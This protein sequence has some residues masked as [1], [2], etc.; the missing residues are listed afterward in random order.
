GRWQ[1]LTGKG[2]ADSV[3]LADF[4]KV[5]PSL[6]DAELEADMDVVLDAVRLGR[7]VR[8][9]HSPKV[10]QPLSRCIIKPVRPDDAERLRRPDLSQLVASELNVRQ[11][12]VAE[13]TAVRSLSAKPNFKR[14]GKRLGA[15]VSMVAAAL[16]AP[17][18]ETLEAIEGGAPVTLSIDGTEVVLERDDVEIQV[19]GRDEYA[20]AGDGRLVLALDVTLDADLL[21][22]GIA[23]EVVHRIQ[24]A[25]KTAGLEIANRIH[26]HLAGAPD[27][28]DAVKH[29]RDMVMNEVLG[30]ALDLHTA[31][32]D[33]L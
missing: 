9:A 33:G 6:I 19:R 23:R 28:L 16:A 12:E 17:P 26:L 3:H 1:A 18:P 32:G 15:M 8:A 20:V 5:D 11:V 22:E 10:R 24:N 27:A 7:T 30:V 14:L 31:A 25:R 4:P 29:H 2:A 13:G 21:R